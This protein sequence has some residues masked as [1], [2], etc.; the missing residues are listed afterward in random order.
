MTEIVVTKLLKMVVQISFLYSFFYIYLF[1]RLMRL[2]QNRENLLFEAEE[3]NMKF[4]HMIR[5]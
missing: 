4:F 2:I 1:E 3:T 5:H